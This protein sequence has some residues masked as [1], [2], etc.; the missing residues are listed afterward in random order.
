MEVA[1]G[2]GLTVTADLLIPKQGLAELDR[3]VFVFDVPGDVCGPWNRDGFERSQFPTTATSVVPTA[4]AASTAAAREH[5]RWLLANPN[6]S[7]QSQRSEE[8]TSELQ[9]QSNLVCRLLL[10]KKNES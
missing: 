7:Q 1:P 2:A 10:E 8:H 9:S 3:G 4:T 6:R 5:D